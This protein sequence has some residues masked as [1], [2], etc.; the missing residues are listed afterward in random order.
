M[1]GR[2]GRWLTALLAAAL[3]A[4]PAL[5]QAPRPVSF[6]AQVIEA[7]NPAQPQKDAAVPDSLL[8]ELQRTFQ[9]KQY[10][11]LGSK[12]S[13]PTAVGAL[14]SPD[15]LP[16]GVT[17]QVTPKSVDGSMI[18][19]DVKLLRGSAPVVA[20]TVRVAPGGQVV[21]GGPTTGAGSL[22]VVLSAR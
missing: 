1:R 3:L 13:P 21:V 18:A 22:I 19:V 15:S 10:K 12:S 16:G 6:T 11:S 5:A 8:R 4:S 9:F 20:T 7:S 14:W 17:L 2:T